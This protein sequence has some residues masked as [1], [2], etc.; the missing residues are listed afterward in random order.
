MSLLV[1]LL[2]ARPGGGSGGA[3]APPLRVRAHGAALEHAC[4]RRHGPT[5]GAGRRVRQTFGE[6][7]EHLLTEHLNADPLSCNDPRGRGSCDPAEAAA[8]GAHTPRSPAAAVACPARFSFAP[9]ALFTKLTSLL[10]FGRGG[11]RGI[12]WV[13]Q[14]IDL[15]RVSQPHF[16][17]AMKPPPDRVELIGAG[18]LG[19]GTGPSFG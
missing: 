18:S 10:C 2:L 13:V 9:S 8:R 12:L 15:W 3:E 17:G 7:R 1:S 11:I 5:P 6:D 16:E 14:S 4:C 19:Y